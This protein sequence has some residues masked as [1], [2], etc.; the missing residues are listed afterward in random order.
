MT[1]KNRSYVKWWMENFL[2]LNSCSKERLIVL[3]SRCSQKYITLPVFHVKGGATTILW[4]EKNFSR[5]YWSTK[6]NRDKL[7]LASNQIHHHPFE[8]KHEIQASLW[9]IFLRISENILILVI[10]S[11]EWIVKRWRCYIMS[12][13]NPFCIWYVVTLYIMTILFL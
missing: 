6:K 2:T 11:I 9:A 1:N 7:M 3:C 10:S 5:V 13:Q 12:N 4:S 8:E